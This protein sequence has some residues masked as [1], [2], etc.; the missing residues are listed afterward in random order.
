MRAHRPVPRASACGIPASK[1]LSVLDHDKAYIY[2]DACT[3]Y[4]VLAND[5]WPERP[6]CTRK[7]SCRDCV[8]SEK[9]NYFL[10]GRTLYTFP[11]ADESNRVTMHSGSPFNLTLGKAGQMAQGLGTGHRT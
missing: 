9:V 10:V 7:L 5:L 8:F 2:L 1:P 6:V 3:V 4:R 11:M